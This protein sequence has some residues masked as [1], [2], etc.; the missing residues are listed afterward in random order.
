MSRVAFL[1]LGIM[2]SRMSRRLL[3]SGFELTVW[4]RTSQ[5]TSAL[6]RSGAKLAQTPKEA[7]TGADFIITM[8]ADPS[9]VLETVLG[10]NGVIEGISKGVTLIDCTTVDTQTPLIIEKILHSKGAHFLESPVTGSKPAA[11]SGE[12]VFMVGGDPKVLESARPVLEPLSKK[13]V[14]MGPVG[15]GACMKLANN[16]VI[17]GSMQALFEGM[18]LGQKAGLKPEAMLEVLTSSAL[19]SL[20][21]K[22]KGTSIRDRKFDPNFSVKHMAKDIHLAL[23]EAHRQGLSLSQLST[24]HNLYESALAQGLGE[25]DFSA[26]IK[27]TERMSGIGERT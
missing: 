15:S 9:S 14:H 7:S 2:G 22:M 6:V 5:K 17:A 12:L 3:V 4:N 11:V 25:E 20:L 19:S 27:V 24:I 21:L 10:P 1:G 26:L 16:L 8:L 13:I 23:A 18:T